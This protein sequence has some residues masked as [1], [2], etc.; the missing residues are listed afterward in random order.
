MK[1]TILKKDRH[2]NEIIEFF[3]GGKTKTT[4]F[5][6]LCDICGV[7]HPKT[8]VNE[9]FKEER[10]GDCDICWNCQKDLYYRR[11]RK[12]RY[13]KKPFRNLKRIVKL[14]YFDKTLYFC[15]S[16]CYFRFAKQKH[17]KTRTEWDKKFSH[18]PKEGKKAY[19]SHLREVKRVVKC[20]DKMYGFDYC[21]KARHTCIW[22]RPRFNHEKDR[23]P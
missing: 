4:Y 19:Y 13:C 21:K 1:I 11:N 6:L 7:I 14:Y 3:K 16:D 12:C 20:I 5:H 15:D 18:L 9:S 22:L 8:R 17:P 10:F 2:S 23:S